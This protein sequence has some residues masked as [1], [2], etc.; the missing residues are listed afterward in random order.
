MLDIKNEMLFWN[1][2]MRDHGMFQ[3]ASLSCKEKEMVNSAAK[4]H[5]AFASLRDQLLSGADAKS[6]IKETKDLINEF[7]QFKKNMLTKL[8][9]C[10]IELTMT[11]TFLN[12]MINEALEYY[13][14]LCLADEKI[15]FNVVLEMIRVHK[16][17]LFDAAG[18]AYF[19]ASQLDATEDIHIKAALDYRKN[20]NALYIEAT[21]LALLY[22]RTLL[23]N[24][25]INSFN[26]KVK[27]L[28]DSFIEFLHEVKALRDE[29]KIMATGTFVGLALDHMIREEEYYL[30]KIEILTNYK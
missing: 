16:I 7:V 19:I 10:D 27:L 11:P 26:D 9:T 25:K 1:G 3:M 8:L 12:D 30:S 13:L 21:Q 2:V 5:L 22:E 28:M 4:F 23:T 29:C 6:K 17:W 20:F 24:S 18:H 14:V 15:K